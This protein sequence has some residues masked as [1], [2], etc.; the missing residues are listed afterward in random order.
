M[1]GFKFSLG[2]KV[3]DELTSFEGV[4]T[5]RS[6]HITGCDRYCVRPTELDENDY[7]DSIWFDEQRLE[8]QEET[9]GEKLLSKFKSSKNGDVGASGSADSGKPTPK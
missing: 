5:V 9:L 7:P 4:V 6:Q 2:E 3:K 8:S 1:S